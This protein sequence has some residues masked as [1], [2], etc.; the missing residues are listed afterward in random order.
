MTKLHSSI[1]D[2]FRDNDYFRL[3]R[4]SERAVFFEPARLQTD[5]S[6]CGV[7]WIEACREILHKNLFKKETFNTIKPSP[8]DPNTARQTIL[9]E[10]ST[11]A[12]TERDNRKRRAYD[13]MV[14]SAAGHHEGRAR[15]R[16]STPAAGFP[17]LGSEAIVAGFTHDLPT[18]ADGPMFE[19][20]PAAGPGLE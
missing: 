14:D 10:V 11:R 18:E 1:K 17:V 19:Q 6:S 5:D 7:Y 16:C 3:A 8:V 15:W 20:S 2:M 9:S 4:L 13:G 12:K